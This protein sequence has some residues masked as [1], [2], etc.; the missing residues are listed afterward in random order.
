ML[1]LGFFL[2]LAGLI[3]F[4]AIAAEDSFT[5][6]FNGKDFTGFTFH[7]RQPNPETKLDPKNTWKVVDGIIQCTGKPNGY[8]ATVKEYGDYILKVKWRFPAEG[9]GGNSG[10]LLHVTAED[11]VWPHAIEAQMYA[12]RAG[13]IWLNADKE[14]KLPLI[15]IDPVR[16]DLDNKDGRH[17]FRIGKD[18]MIEK[19]LGEWN[20]YVI[21]CQGGD[22]TLVING[23]KVNEAKRC[24]L[25]KGRIAFQ[26]EGAPVE[27][28]DIEIKPLKKK[29]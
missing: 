10:I 27:F 20:E 11:K 19:P 16:K 18:E 29:D 15:E 3:P 4:S 26:S 7:L 13:D 12:G 24:S 6:L 14:G 2:S 17:Y 23:K 28:K 22:I 25:T 21:T 1:R 9:K 5:P 8:F